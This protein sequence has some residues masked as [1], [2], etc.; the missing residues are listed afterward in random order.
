MADTVETVGQY[1]QQEAAHELILAEGHGFLAGAAIG[2][3]ILISK[4][5]TVLIGGD[6]ALV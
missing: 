3:V 6:E 5:D 4:S 1:M 2:P